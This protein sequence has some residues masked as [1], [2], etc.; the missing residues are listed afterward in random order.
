MRPVG[1][2][3]DYAACAETDPEAFFPENGNQRFI[4][5]AKKVC[6]TCEVQTECLQYAFEVDE[7]HGIWGGLTALERQRIKRKGG[8][9]A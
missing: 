2:W 5:A 9:A 6:A 7:Q 4:T 3:V 1:D 8:S